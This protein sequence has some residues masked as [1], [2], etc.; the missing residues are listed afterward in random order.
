VFIE[1]TATD[2]RKAEIALD[3]MITMFSGYCSPQYLVECV[4]VIKDGDHQI[5]PKLHSR[6]EIINVDE[7]N[8]KIGIEIDS[9]KMQLLLGKM[10]LNA[11]ENSPNELSVEIPPTRSDIL[12][13]IDIVEDVAIA[14]GFNNLTK[15]IPKTNCFSEEVRCMLL[16]IECLMITR[17]NL[18]F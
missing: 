3:T 12:H 16:L 11:T 7:T 14:Y 13:S 15:T 9:K 6:Q 2:L 18:K 1:C 10:G 4:E 8:R 17:Q 5:Y